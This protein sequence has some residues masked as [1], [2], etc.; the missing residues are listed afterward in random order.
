MCPPWYICLEKKDVSLKNSSGISFQFRYS[1][2]K[3]LSEKFIPEYLENISNVKGQGELNRLIR[4][5][6][7]RHLE[8]TNNYHTNTILHVYDKRHLFEKKCIS[9]RRICVYN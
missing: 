2:T 6:A 5:E 4:L 3:I 8:E 1:F 9:N 7:R